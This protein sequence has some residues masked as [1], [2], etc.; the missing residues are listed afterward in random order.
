MKW[1][2]KNKHK[3]SHSTGQHYA[4]NPSFPAR[5]PPSATS[6]SQIVARLPDPILERIFTFVCPHSQDET[7][8]DCE[9]S[10]IEDTC[11]LCDLRDLSHCAQASKRWRVL[12]TKVLVRIDSVHYCPQ[13]EILAEKRKRKSFYSRNAE[14]EDTAAARLRLLA[15]TLRSYQGTL[16][17]HVQYM[18]I[19]YMTRET[20]KPDLARAVAVCPN[21]KYVD[22]PDGLY[23][24]DPSCHGLKQE[25]QA[26]CPDLRKMSYI[27]GAERSLEILASGQVW[28]NLEVLELTKLNM[29]SNIMRQALGSLPNLH[30]LK[31]TDMK[32][33][34]DDLFRH[35]DIL[36]P[37]P[38]LAELSFENTPNVTADG[39]TAYLS[40]PDTANALKTLLL[41]ATGIVPGTLHQ[42]L[43]A[44]PALR[45]LS[46]IESVTSSFPAS[47]NVPTLQS[48]SLETFHYEIT[49]G[50]SANSYASTTASYYNYLT[51]SLM[52]GGLP[53]L[54]EL[55]IQDPDFPESL[56]DFRPPA[57]PFMSDPDNFTPPMSPFLGNPNRFSSNNPFAKMQT[58]PGLSQDLQVYSK[59]LDEEEWNFSRVQPPAR[60][61][62]GSASAPRP[63]S[64]YGLGEGLGRAWTQQAGV[65]KS[66]IV[67]NGFG[68]LLAVPADANGRPSSSAGEKKRG[69]TYDMWR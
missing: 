41:T 16:A 47:S 9:K 54:K 33:F 2:N 69:S 13:E 63:V 65:R 19:P 1:F 27:G 34:H 68:G 56:V 12:A 31:V 36:P 26:R 35:S 24:D 67:G 45:H 44:A 42:I 48:R 61:R 38:I 66:A 64:S 7:Y 46:L 11:M 30:A 29:D 37:F 55:Y 3:K 23:T 21:L 40:R 32:A 17:L 58:G 28:R 20:C 57:A 51:R 52:S 25:V 49:S 18:K 62:R 53:N 60:G 6:Q 5:T 50:T 43:L 39:L 22:L 8:E 4:A 15:R 14:P 10:S 59:G